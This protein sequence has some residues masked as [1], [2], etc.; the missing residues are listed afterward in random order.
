MCGAWQLRVGGALA[1]GIGS[2][3]INWV[4][5]LE[6][7]KVLIW[8]VITLVGLVMVKPGRIV[9][10]LLDGGELGVGPAKLKFA[11]RVK[12]IADAVERNDEVAAEPEAPAQNPLQEAA[13]PYTT[14]ING[15]GKV[16]EGLEDALERSGLDKIDRRNPM[17]CVLRLRR[18]NM[19]GR[20][21]RE[22][23]S[24]ALGLSKQGGARR[25][26]AA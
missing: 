14:V 19:I 12:E 9:D 8:P 6:F 18:A 7:T 3:T 17:D 21:L 22:Q 24:G 25:F 11:T 5:V 15:W 26:P 1:G 20:K 4:L 10:A 23:H 13:D 2:V 16:V